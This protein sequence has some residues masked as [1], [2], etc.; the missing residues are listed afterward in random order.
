MPNLKEKQTNIDG[1]KKDE[2]RQ[3]FL[4]VIIDKHI[5]CIWI[6]YSP[7]QAEISD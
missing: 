3:I 7:N 5:S 1:A 2:L 4:I 6:T